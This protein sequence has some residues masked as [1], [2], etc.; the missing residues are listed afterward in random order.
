MAWRLACIE[1]LL[2]C[3]WASEEKKKSKRAGACQKDRIFDGEEIGKSA[4][5]TNDTR[6]PASGALDTHL[7]LDVLFECNSYNAARLTIEKIDS[8]YGLIQSARRNHIVS[9]CWID[10]GNEYESIANR[11]AFGRMVG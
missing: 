2:V 11:R 8:L 6:Q 5:V 3:K 7:W 10:I 9:I 4:K 1:K